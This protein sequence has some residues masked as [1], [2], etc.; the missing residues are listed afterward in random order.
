MSVHVLASADPKTADGVDRLSLLIAELNA[1][2]LEG[3]GIAAERRFGP[4]C[5]EA[6]LA[7]QPPPDGTAFVGHG[8]PDAVPGHDGRGL[9]AGE[10]ARRLAGRWLHT[11]ACDSSRLAPRW[12]AAGASS[13]ASYSNRLA[14]HWSSDDL[15]DE[16]M[17]VF[18]ALV[19]EVTSALAAGPSAMADVKARL[20]AHQERIT[21]WAQGRGCFDL[22]LFCEQLVINLRLDP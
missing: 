7:V 5:T 18:R 2:R 20:A 6:E 10:G 11:L 8:L 1:E 19:T 17:P 9:F 13:V 15:D 21:N 4:R 22:V 16:I 3:T 12:R 14:A